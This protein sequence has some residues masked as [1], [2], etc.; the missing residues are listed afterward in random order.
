LR[1]RRR[2]RLPTWSAIPAGTDLADTVRSDEDGVDIFIEEAEGEEVIDG[3][4]VGLA[5]PGPVE[6]GIG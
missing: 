6:V 3:G 1:N 5:R 4:A 2:R